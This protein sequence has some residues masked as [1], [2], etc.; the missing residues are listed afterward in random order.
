M[1]EV[2]K[3]GTSELKDEDEVEEHEENEDEA[4][5]LEGIPKPHSASKQTKAFSKDTGFGLLF[6]NRQSL[7]W[8]QFLLDHLV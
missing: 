2:L 7:M 5:L 3:E 6:I 4:I 1:P 8:K